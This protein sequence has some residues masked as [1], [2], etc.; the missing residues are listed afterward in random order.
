MNLTKFKRI[1]N[2]NAFLLGF[3]NGFEAEISAEVL[4][5]HCPCAACSGEEVLLYKFIPKNKPLLNDNS[6]I[7]ED[8]KLTGNYAIQLFWKDGHNTGIYNW[9]FL[10]KLI[11]IYNNEKT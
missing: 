7:L 4:R 2:S 1:Q 10:F 11:Q 3:D 8:A 6:Y 9:D 5:N